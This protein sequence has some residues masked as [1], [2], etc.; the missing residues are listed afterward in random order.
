MNGGVDFDGQHD[1]TLPNRLNNSQ[2]GKHESSDQLIKWRCGTSIDAWYPQTWD[3][4]QF[5]ANLFI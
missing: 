5:N 1:N 3:I 2:S 4:F